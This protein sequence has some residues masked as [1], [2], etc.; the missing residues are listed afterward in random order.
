MSNAVLGQ[1]LF[2]GNTDGVVSAV[3]GT[4]FDTAALAAMVGGIG[5]SFKPTENKKVIIPFDPSIGLAG[6]LNGT[7][8]NIHTR[9]AGVTVT[10]V[11][12]VVKLADGEDFSSGGIVGLNAAGEGVKTSPVWNLGASNGVVD[13]VYGGQSSAALDGVTGVKVNL[14]AGAQ[15]VTAPAGEEQPSS[16]PTPTTTT[17]RRDV[18][19]GKE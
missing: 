4:E 17:R 13:S 9:T 16:S 6:I 11:D 14:T 3:I 8:I 12:V 2:R 7:D 15:V 10:G 5:V 19:L 1:P 18:Q